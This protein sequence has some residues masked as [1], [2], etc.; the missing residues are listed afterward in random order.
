ME[1]ENNEIETI[2]VLARDYENNNLMLMK[3]S[4]KIRANN[5]EGKKTIVEIVD[6]GITIDGSK[7]NI[8]EQFN[9]QK[10]HRMQNLKKEQNHNT[11]DTRTENSYS[12]EHDDM[13]FANFANRNHQV[14][15]EVPQRGKIVNLQEYANSKK[16]QTRDTLDYVKKEEKK[17]KQREIAGYKHFDE[18]QRLTEIRGKARRLIAGALATAT[19]LTAG[20]G[21]VHAVDEHQTNKAYIEQYDGDVARMRMAIEESMA[22][23]FEETLGKEN[24]NVNIEEYSQGTGEAGS[25]IIVTD[26]QGNEIGRFTNAKDLRG[27]TSHGNNKAKK[28]GKIADAY[29]AIEDSKDAAKVL[30]S[31]EEF[32]EEK[33]IQIDTEKTPE[34][35]ENTL[36]EVDEER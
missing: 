24:L 14:Q 7:G 23:E 28:L 10:T 1:T 15:Q 32:R 17:N 27:G 9:Q 30:E 8:L 22:K 4:A 3:I 19:V 29:L 16:A 26:E 18:I 2:K 35:E 21:V 31:M 20:T 34:E 6:E 11:V 25:V 33:D 5:Q 36:T 13:A 12:I